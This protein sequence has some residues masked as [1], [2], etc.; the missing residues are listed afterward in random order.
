[1]RLLQF[2]WKHDIIINVEQIYE[3]S[4]VE[5]VWRSRLAWS[6]ARDWK[7][8]RRQKRLEGS[9]PSFS[10]IPILSEVVMAPISLLL[11][12]GCQ[13]GVAVLGYSLSLCFSRYSMMAAWTMVERGQ[14]RLR[15]S[16]SSSALIS[17]VIRTLILGYSAL[18][19]VPPPFCSHSHH[20]TVL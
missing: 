3:S 5:Q 16:C 12:V 20:I 4:I 19:M 2:A 14:S 13:K 10:A 11:V 9:N 6:R 18:L 8:R 15:A 1:M 17:G 7:S